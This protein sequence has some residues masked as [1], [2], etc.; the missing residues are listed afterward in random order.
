MIAYVFIADN[1]RLK[2]LFCSSA[3][4]RQNGARRSINAQAPADVDIWRR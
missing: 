2:R 1:S 3:R 4:R